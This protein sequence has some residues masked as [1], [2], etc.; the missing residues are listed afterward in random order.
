MRMY[1]AKNRIVLLAGAHRREAGWFGFRGAI[2]SKISGCPG[3][4]SH[5]RNEEKQRDMGTNR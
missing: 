5:G 4:R 3:L 2:R 1:F